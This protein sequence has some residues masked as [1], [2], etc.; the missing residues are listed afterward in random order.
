[1]NQG[2]AT[3]LYDG[4]CGL[5][6]FWVRFVTS[7]DALH[8]FRFIPL[9][10]EDGQKILEKFNLPKKD[11]DSLVLFEDEVCYQKSDAVLRIFRRLPKLWSILYIF[12]IVP[13]F[14]RDVVYD[15]IAARR[16][17]WFGKKDRFFS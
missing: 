4:V 12:V 13:K 3:V 15:F 5:C 11:F 7:R 1:M 8:R 17:R 14:C 6:N 2:L 10:S 16:Y 9:Q